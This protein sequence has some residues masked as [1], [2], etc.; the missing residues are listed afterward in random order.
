MSKVPGGKV[1]KS[2]ATQAAGWILVL[3]GIAG[4][5]LP[6]PGLLGVFGGMALLATQYTWAERRLAPVKHVAVRTAA[7]S[8]A[9]WPRICASIVGMIVLI[10]IGIA[11]GVR[12]RAPGWWPVSER[13]WLVGGWATG[14]A[15][16]FSG[17]IAGAMVV[18]SYRKFRE[19]RVEE[20]PKVSNDSGRYSE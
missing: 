15:L 2:L 5:V 7:E 4:L 9:S 19:I 11:W 1:V 6:G 14:C 20:G 10:T 17:L 12:P 18:Y 8:V 3:L 13:W 16:I